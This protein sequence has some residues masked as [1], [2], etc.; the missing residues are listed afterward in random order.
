MT[1]EEFVSFCHA[2]LDELDDQQ[3]DHLADSLMVIAL[4]QELAAK[5]EGAN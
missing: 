2:E 3:T 4:K 5:L 1:A